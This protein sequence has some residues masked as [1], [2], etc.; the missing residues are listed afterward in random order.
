MALPAATDAGEMPQ[1]VSSALFYLMAYAITNLGAWGVVLALERK[2]GKGLSIDDYAGLGARYPALALV[3]ALFM[4]SL[5]G[6]PPTIGFVGKFY[7]FRAAIASNMFWLAVVGVITSLI[8][9]FY[10]LRVIVVMYMQ[11]GKAK[12]QSAGWL[13]FSMAL[14]ALA[15]LIIG[16][17]PGPLFALA[18]GAQMMLFP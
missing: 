1:A 18:R 2:E 11:S 16:I 10:Y 4:L 15:T 7:V 3:M 17:F 12:A 13:S 5:T 9:A 6:V 14:T 8:S